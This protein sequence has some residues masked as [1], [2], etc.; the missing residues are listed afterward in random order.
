MPVL[1]RFYS[2]ATERSCGEGFEVALDGRPVRTPLGV[3]LV[4]PTR[5]LGAAIAE[6]WRAQAAEIVFSAM[7]LMG[8]ANAAIDRAR[9]DPPTFRA[10]VAAYGRNDLLCQRA[11]EPDELV[12]RQAAAWDSWLDWAVERHGARLATGTGV[13]PIAQPVEA[14]AALDVA[15]AALDEWGLAAAGVAVAASGSLVLALA[16]VEGRLAGEEAL[17][18][19]ALEELWQNERWGV[20]REAVARREGIAADLAAA[21]RFARLARARD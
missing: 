15:V 10:S 12:R 18:L 3:P 4:V 19:A 20:D 2:G 13:M 11:E 9:A 14:T 5:A 16:V 6:E 17:A 21:A 1:K 8:I 7:P